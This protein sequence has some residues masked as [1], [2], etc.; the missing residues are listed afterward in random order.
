MM[1]IAD[2]FDALAASDRPY[3]IAVPVGKALDILHEEAKAGLMDPEL[4][5][6][7]IES[8][9]YERTAKGK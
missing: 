8:K 6:I 5:G 9:V 7:F 2:V 3:K 1:A 4:L